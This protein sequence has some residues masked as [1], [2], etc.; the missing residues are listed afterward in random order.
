[1]VGELS[2]LAGW[3]ASDAGHYQQAQRLYLSGVTATQAAADRALGAQP[4]SSL[5][6]QIANIGNRDDAVL[7]ARSAVTGAP[8]A[9]PLVRALLLE[10]LAWAAAR[11]HDPDTTRRALDAVDDTYAQRSTGIA[12][13]EWVYWLDR[14]PK[15][16]S[17]PAAASSH[18]GTQPTPNPC[19][20]EP[21]PATTTATSAKS[22]STRP[23][24]P[25]ATP[26]PATSTPPAPPSNKS[27][28]PPHRPTPYVYGAAS[29][30][31][32]T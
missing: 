29:T 15:S 27:A 16:T 18:S 21:S 1:V 2:Q 22:P 32:P 6:Y 23:G 26:K 24:S 19:S 4:L 28:P 12:E 8:D 13:P 11:A 25:K 9:T 3:I 17:W 7:I 31:S 20:P 5:A 30:P 10:R 14:G